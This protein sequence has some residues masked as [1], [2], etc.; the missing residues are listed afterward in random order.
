[1]VSLMGMGRKIATNY[2]VIPY[3]TI[4][5]KLKGGYTDEKN[6]NR[7]NTKHINNGSNNHTRIC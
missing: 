1:M 5:I 4:I 7:I 3:Q 6:I 2:L